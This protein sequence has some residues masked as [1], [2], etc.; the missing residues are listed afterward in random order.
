MK[1]GSKS[2]GDEW[3]G[4]DDS[5]DDVDYSSKFDEIKVSFVLYI[6]LQAASCKNYI[7]VIVA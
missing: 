7:Y 1:V 6:Q 2:K 4:N 3:T 5:D